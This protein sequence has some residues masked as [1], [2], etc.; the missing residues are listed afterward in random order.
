V[1]GEVA[2]LF[3]TVGADVTGLSAGMN[4]ASS[5]VTRA[6]GTLSRA[7]ARMSAAISLPLLVIGKQALGAA[8]D[9]EAGMLI[10]QG[11]IDPTV[12]DMALLSAAIL[13]VGSST[14]NFGVDALGAQDAVTELLRSGESASIIFGDLNAVIEDGG[15]V[16]GALKPIIDLAAAS[17]VDMTQAGELAVAM[18]TTFGL[19]AEDL[20]DA[21]DFLVGAANES[22][23]E[24]DELAEAF[25]NTGPMLALFGWDVEQ[26]TVA[27][28]LLSQAGVRS[29]EAGTALKRMFMNMQR[30]TEKVTEALGEL[31]LSLYDL[32]GNLKDAPVIMKEF[33]DALLHGTSAMGELTEQQRN[34]YLQ[35]IAGFHGIKAL[36]PLLDAGAVGWD[37]MAGAIA[38]ANTA[39]EIAT[40]RIGGF[41]GQ[42]QLLKKALVDTMIRGATPFMEEFLTP[43]AAKLT[44][45]VT[46][47]ANLDPHTQKMII[48]VGL[49]VAAAGP[50]LLILGA[51]ASILGVLLSPVGLVI[52]AIVALVA[53]F[54]ALSGGLGPAVDNLMTIGGIIADLAAG[55]I[56]PLG[57]EGFDALVR[58]D[59]ALKKLGLSD[60]TVA[61]ILAFSIG[62]KTAL[63]ETV[64]NVKTWAGTFWTDVQAGF[65]ENGLF[66]AIAAGLKDMSGLGDALAP[67]V[68]FLGDFITE[69][70]GLAWGR[71]SE[72]APMLTTALEAAFAAVQIGDW[73]GVLVALDPLGAEI[74]TRFAGFAAQ[75]WTDF[76][77]AFPTEAEGLEGMWAGITSGFDQTVTTIG[78]KIEEMRLWFEGIKTSVG[79]VFSFI[80]QVLR[81]TFGDTFT[82]AWASLQEAGAEFI[83]LWEEIKVL[84]VD[85]LPVLEG[86]AKIFG[87]VLV[88]AI[89]I[90]LS[91][92]RGFVEGVTAALPHLVRFITGIVETVDGMILVI[93]NAISWIAGLIE[94]DK[95]KMLAAWEGMKT[96]AV[97]IWTGMKTA[98]V[99]QVL[100]VVAAVEGTISGFIDGI[101]GFFTSLYDQL[102]G[103]SIVPDIM[104][105]ITTAFT[106]MFTDV[107]TGVAVFFTDISSSI[108]TGL[109][110]AWTTISGWY[111]SIKNALEAPFLSA[112]EGIQGLIGEIEGFLGSIKL[113]HIKVPH[114]S[115]SWKDT[116]IMGIKVPSVSVNWYAQGLDAIIN[117][118]T[119]I[120]VG[121]SGP[122]HV[123]VT[124]LGGGGQSM[125]GG[126]PGGPA[127]VNPASATRALDAIPTALWRV[128]TTVADLMNTQYRQSRAAINAVI[129]RTMT[130]QRATMHAIEDYA[131]EQDVPAPATP[132][133]EGGASTL[134]LIIDV[135]QGK[136]KVSTLSEQLDLA[137]DVD[138]NMRRIS[139]YV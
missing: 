127:T 1:A 116:G 52:G 92:V 12:D 62:L 23:T 104:T 112:K 50:F 41:K 60:E 38:N 81:D 66:G 122:E 93:G 90:A 56:G 18:M 10:I 82:A 64:E 7:G 103:N 123:Q 101:V 16:T 37:N 54:V 61:D 118:P 34:S 130:T 95:E 45:I 29:S 49:I 51:L 109:T 115:V 28:A 17:T 24:V 87:G 89:G 133:A 86:A 83:P 84:F 120:G 48:T 39:S 47:F 31:G 111:D 124:P 9:F 76:Q 138:T 59:G 13:S 14:E 106:T 33:G 72:T 119:L 73:E 55:I 67:L 88:V 136:K 71:L 117:K 137:H 126:H 26:V 43:A 30:P 21:F 74:A 129:I 19:G 135:M 70:V 102:V 57:S 110:N 36:S 131:A 98:I 46:A 85:L 78:E 80:G 134:H 20:G 97:K 42:M 11:L 107:L 79:G 113:P 77:A 3:V 53:G 100:M 8:A 25:V 108:T 5:I 65:G 6:A 128:G 68:T 132:P 94:G 27:L 40:L 99:E 69:K 44:E 125:L 96:G 75:A 114:I 15:K 2:K 91:L 35:T 22:V 4:S 121:E 32:N 58:F 63:A 139:V 105:A